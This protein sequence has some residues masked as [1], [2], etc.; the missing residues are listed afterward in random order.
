MGGQ[1]LISNMRI[2]T[3]IVAALIAFGYSAKIQ[4]KTPTFS[5]SEERSF[6]GSPK[7]NIVFA[8]GKSDTMILTKFNNGEDEDK[9]ETEEE[10]ED[11]RYLGHLENEPSACIAMVGCPGVEKVEFTIFSKNV[12]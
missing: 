6:D 7:I 3:I 11:C 8:N 4:G 10:V 2:Q 9:I 5:L 12:F 1:F